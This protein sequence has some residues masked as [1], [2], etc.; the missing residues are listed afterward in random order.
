MSNVDVEVGS[1]DV[2]VE[3]DPKLCDVDKIIAAIAATGE[4]VSKKG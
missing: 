1:P 3:Y 2:T 4:G